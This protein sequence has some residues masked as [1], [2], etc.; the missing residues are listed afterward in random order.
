[1]ATIDRLGSAEGDSVRLRAWAAERAGEAATWFVIGIAGLIAVFIG[2][3]VDA[4]RHNNGAG[5]ETLLSFANPGH[6]VA[7]IG[8]LVS[9]SAMLAGLSVS[10]LRGAASAQGAVR[11]MVPLTA[12][13]VAVAA[14]GVG[15]LTYMGATGVTVG[16]S[17]APGDGTSAAAAGHTTAVAAGDEALEGVGIASKLD[18]EG[19]LDSG[20]DSGGDPSG[21]DPSSVQGALTQGANGQAGGKHDQGKHATYT[22]MMELP[23]DQLASMFPDGI[24]DKSDIPALRTELAAVRAVAEKY[25]TIEA[26]NAGGYVNTTSDV[27]F[28]GMHF[29]NTK[30]VA[31]GKFNASEPEGLL[32]S[33]IDDGPP[34]LVGVWF[35]QIPGIGGVKRDVEPVGFTSSLDLWH[36]HIGLCL[37]GLSGASEGETRESCDAKG[38]RFTKDLRWMMHVWVAPEASENKDG[39]FAYLNSD[40]YEKQQAAKKA[41]DSAAAPSGTTQ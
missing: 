30:F 33:K 11:R 7:G 23:D 16:H 8:L 38:G 10:A 32:F 1:M 17:V 27:P 4:W 31:D 24:V 34:K 36:S 15:A 12:A 35:L 39:F 22:Q 29:L 6:V 18:E 41:A 26:A 25:P 9:A 14:T 20:G 3:A 13:W 2:L 37:V 5:E 40:L 19:L 28:M 21:D